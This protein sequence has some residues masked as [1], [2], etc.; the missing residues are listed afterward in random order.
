MVTGLRQRHFLR[1]KVQQAI[2][3]LRRL[4]HAERVAIVA[5]YPPITVVQFEE[6]G[7]ITLD[8]QAARLVRGSLTA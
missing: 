5:M 4:T 6:Q 8:Q 1:W 7:W 3:A 2:N